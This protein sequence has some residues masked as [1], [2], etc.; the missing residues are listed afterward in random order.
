ML[1]LTAARQGSAY[2]D[3]TC[4]CPGEVIGKW[5][6]FEAG[7]GQLPLTT[8]NSIIAVTHLSADLLPEVPIPSITAIGLSVAGMNL[9]GCWFGAMPVCD[10]SGSFAA[11]YRFG[12]RSGASIV[13]LRL[14]KLLIGLIFGESLIDLLKRFPNALLAVVVIVAGL[15]LAGVGESLNTSRARDIDKDENSLSMNDTLPRSRLLEKRLDEAER[16]RRWN[17]ML[18]AAGLLPAFKNDA[19]AGMFC[20]WS[21]EIACAFCK[22]A[23]WKRLWDAA[24]GAARGTLEGHSG[25]VDAV[26]FSPN[27]KLVA[28]A[29]RDK[30][31]GFWDAAT[32]APNGV[33]RTDL[34]IR[35]LPFSSDG[36]YLE[37]NT[38]QLDISSH[39]SITIPLR[40]K[41]LRRI[42]VKEH[43]LAQDM[44]NVL[45]LPPDYR[46]TCGTVRNIVI[47]GA[48]IRSC[49]VLGI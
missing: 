25:L 46:A 16:K 37:T 13:F 12:A 45:W 14:L 44:E 40:S 31:V 36:Q 30:T 5:E 1:R 32:G 26:A 15:E 20:H 10:G 19:V 27:G 6:F 21:Y 9:F 2:G 41:P 34:A 4:K 8:L 3:L 18:V 39:F 17:V 24:T 38:G 23:S 7:I 47:L 11:Q 49:Y 43:W 33:R 42:L 22:T 29:S 35:E 28:S 48:C